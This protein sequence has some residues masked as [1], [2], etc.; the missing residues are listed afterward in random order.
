MKKQTK[1]SL[2]AKRIMVISAVDVSFKI[3][4]IAQIKAAQGAGYEVYGICSKGSYFDWLTQQGIKMIP[5]TIKRSISPLSDLVAL[6][7][8]YRCFNRLR[9]DIVHTH[10]PKACLFGQLAAKMAGVPIIISTL[11]G[12]YF[13]DN[14]KPLVRWFHIIMEKIAAKCSTM[15]LSQNPE[16]IET[17]IKLKICKPERIKLLGNGV[18]LNKFDPKRFDG[19]FKKEKRKEIG[20]PEDA[21][22]IGIIGRLVE[23]KGY[24]EL[25]EAFGE[26]IKTHDNVWLVIVGPDEPEKADRISTDIFKQYD[27]EPWTLYLGSRDDIPELMSCFDIYVLPSWREGFPRSAIEAAAMSLP[28]VATNIRGCRQVVENGVNGILVPVRDAK[29]LTEALITLIDNP[30]SRMKMG[31]AGYEKAH[32]EF[33]EKKVCQIVLDTYR[34][35]SNKI[36]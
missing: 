16:D 17:A 20:I 8:M 18:D 13:H 3:L 34:E 33:D 30:G 9:I 26:M 25:C 15:I 5:V 22:V 4:L 35:C 28:I 32:R 6:W 27:I 7:K 23:E 11:H 29:K 21:V 2:T 14:M 19:K 36:E 10:T 12:F 1:D 31:Q 24:L